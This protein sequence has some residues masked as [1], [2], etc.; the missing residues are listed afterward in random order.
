MFLRCHRRKKNGKLHRY[1]SIVESRRVAGSSP[2]QRQVLYLGEI[3][4]SQE[5]AWRKCIEVFD[6]D[7]DT[8]E[9][10]YLFAADQ[11][12]ADHQAN[13]LSLVM[14]ELR[15]VRPRSFGDCWLGCLLWQELGLDAFWF[16]KLGGDRGGVPW[17]A[18]L[19]VLAVNRLC[20]P[21][22]E[23]AVHRHWFLN[24]SMDE[25]LGVDFAAAAKD[26]L[27]RC[28]DRILPH[29]EALFQHLVE[30]WKTLF[31]AR[32]DVL[33]YDL[34]S[35]YFEGSC[36]EIP[37]ARH[38]YSRD[39]RPDCRQVVI[40]LVVT[41]EGLPLAYEVLP[42]NTSDKTTL[43]AFLEKI[44]SMYGKAR[45]V[46]VMDRGIPT[47]ATL[48]K[49]RQ[50]QV[51]YLV[52][53]PKTLLNKLEKDL[54]DKPW[55]KVH[56]DMAVRL[57]EREGEL[58][59]Q[60]KSEQRRLKET[61]MRRR[62]LKRL[63][64]GLN[65]LKR[66]PPSRDKLLKHVAVLQKE[67]GRVASFVK[68]Q[69]PKPD[70]PVNRKTFTCRFDRKAWKLALERDGSYI[71]RASIPWEDFPA[72]LEKRAPVLWEWYM[73]L[74]RVEDAFKTIKSD[75][76]LRPIHHQVQ[77]RVE[78]HILVAFLGYCLTATLRMKL[79]ASAPGLTPQAAL[80]SLSAIQMIEVQVPTS[81]GRVLIMPRH[82]EPE[83]QQEMILE[84]LNL[85]LPP[86][87]PPRIRG[88][89]LELASTKN[90]AFV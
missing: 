17:S 87:P 62:K 51:A 43:T 75:L 34:T 67:A 69:E 48:A 31:D 64:H 15:L 39:G 85:E 65:R 57:L 55:E 23:F 36:A 53:T 78:A 80:Q 44:Q 47:A 45:R 54:L 86:Q 19:Q 84:I 4:D 20:D 3:S 50:D 61:A 72:D 42:G 21:L 71:L 63:I 1:W 7:K 28:L 74:V 77:P 16:A 9:Q 8:R 6:E 38:G 25:L 81:D 33:L 88:G 58:Y 46:W 83:P 73:Q 29:K 26:R 35:T 18:V 37:K 32:F 27:Y 70:E 10:L 82:T 89:K 40:A 5:L 30:R 66:R 41:P 59:V 76:D 11:I 79:A 52:G 14:P 13:A 60:A 22:T 56:D 68:V 2:V 49:M 12:I 24:S 90:R